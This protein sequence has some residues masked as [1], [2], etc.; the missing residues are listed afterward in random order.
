[1]LL[2]RLVQSQRRAALRLERAVFL[3]HPWLLVVALAIILG[4]RQE[5]LVLG[6][7]L[8]LG[9]GIGPVYPQM[10]SRVLSYGE[11]GN[12]V[13]MLAGCGAS[14]LPLMTGLVSNWTGSLRAG[15]TVPLA[16]AVAMGC[17]ALLV[18]RRERDVALV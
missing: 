6:G 1:M 18:S 8:L 9:L 2:S 5:W 3:V 11:G 15:L 12:T 14:V 17:I 13:F 4:C 7:A 10:L 16:C